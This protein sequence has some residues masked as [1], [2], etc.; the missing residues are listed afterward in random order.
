[1]TMPYYFPLQTLQR[2][3]CS[4]NQ[5]HELELC[6]DHKEQHRHDLYIFVHRKYLVH[7]QCKWNEYRSGCQTFP[8]YFSS[9]LICHFLKLVSPLDHLVFKL[10][11]V[12]QD[13][14]QRLHQHLVRPSMQAVCFHI[15]L[16]HMRLTELG[17]KVKVQIRFR[18][19]DSP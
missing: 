13:Q 1:M 15:H 12:L 10:Y 19:G 16:H 3:H 2:R 4:F 18:L 9:Q 6:I 5:F 17:Q 8:S 7:H 14:D 11:W